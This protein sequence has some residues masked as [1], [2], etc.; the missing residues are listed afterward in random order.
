[1]AIT[2]NNDSR[3][4]YARAG[5]SLMEIMIAVMI[6]GLVA[7]LVAPKFMQ[8]LEDSRISAAKSTTKTLKNAIMMYQSDTHQYPTKLKDLIKKPAGDAAKRWKHAYLDAEE[9]PEDPWGNKFYYKV[10]TGA[11]HPYELRSWGSGE[12]KS[13][14]KEQWIDVW[15]EK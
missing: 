2:V 7:G 5:F 6:L 13:T 11:K 9:E 8:F 3:V 14:P 4:K 1:M 12:G 15:D 10:T